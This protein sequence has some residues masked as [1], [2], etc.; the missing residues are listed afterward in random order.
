MSALAE[1]LLAAQRQAIG[2]A[3]KAFV[4]DGINETDL[5]ETLDAIG[6]TD[7][8]DQGYLLAS[9]HALRAFGAPAPN[10]TIA[11]KPSGDTEP[12][13]EAQWTL[14]RRLADDRKMIAPVGPLTKAE[15]SELITKLKA[16]A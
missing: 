14:I 3:T 6:A 7:K 16:G 13:S 2:A 5:L 1:A 4:S 12:A 8:A 9:L 11:P 15:A 10:G